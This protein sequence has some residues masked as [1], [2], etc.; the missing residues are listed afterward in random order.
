MSKPKPAVGAGSGSRE[1]DVVRR[2]TESMLGDPRT[3]HLGE[4]LLPSREAVGELVELIRRVMF[5]G[6]FGQRGL[7]QS[8]LGSHVAGLVSRVREHAEA[9]AR[10]AL[11]YME[12]LR[13]GTSKG[14]RGKPGSGGASVDDRACEVASAFV[15]RLPELRRLLSLDVQAAYDGDPAAIHPDETIICYPGVDAVFAHR[16][17]HEFYLMEVPLLPRIIQEMAHS[18]TGIDIHPGAT[19]GESFFIDHGGAVVIGETTVI[20]SHVRLYQ[21]VTLGAKSLEKDAHGRV[22]KGTKR[23]PTIGD[24]VTIYAGAVILGGDTVIGDDCV[25]GGGVFV[26]RSVP[27]GH[28]ARQREPELV[29]RAHATGKRRGSSPEI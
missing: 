29:V 26:T 23:H 8:G 5:P 15:E 22:V 6:F 17:A 28:V 1:G 13:G 2:L 20:G 14:S 19:I 21:G 24:R 3:C 11:R 12:G 10:A 18:R 7:S 25:I 27:A 4:P 16:V 9:E